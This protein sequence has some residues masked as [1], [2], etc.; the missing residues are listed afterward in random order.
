MIYN[1]FFLLLPGKVI[2][3]KAEEVAEMAV[4]HYQ[5]PFTGE[6][7]LKIHQVVIMIFATTAITIIIITTIVITAISLIG[8]HLS[9]WRHPMWALPK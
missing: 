7:Y 2:G 3:R 8:K 6:Y 4:E 9:G 5:L 1:D